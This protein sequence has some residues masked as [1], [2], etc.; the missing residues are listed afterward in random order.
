MKNEFIKKEEIVFC[1]ECGGLLKKEFSFVVEKIIYLSVFKPLKKRQLNF[2]QIHKIPYKV[3][4]SFFND[5]L[6]YFTDI[7]V[8][9]NGKPVNQDIKWAVK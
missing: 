6:R 5:H 4:K 8:D 2:C 1:D 7:E 9:K 3:I